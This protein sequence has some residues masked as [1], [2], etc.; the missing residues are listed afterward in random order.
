MRK[1]CVTFPQGGG[2]GVVVSGWKPL[3]SVLAMRDV[4]FGPEMENSGSSMAGFL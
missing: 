1:S 4:A 2:D 3:L